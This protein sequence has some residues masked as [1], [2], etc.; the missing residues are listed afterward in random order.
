MIKLNL[1]PKKNKIKS[2]V[3]LIKNLLNKLPC[4]VGMSV[5]SAQTLTVTSKKMFAFS[6]QLFVV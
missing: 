1:P 3:R 6:V 2:K 5:I 4:L